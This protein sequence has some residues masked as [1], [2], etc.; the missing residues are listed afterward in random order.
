MKNQNTTIGFARIGSICHG[1]MRHRHLIPALAYELECLVRINRDALAA[2][3]SLEQFNA[4]ITEAKAELPNAENEQTYQMVDELFD[5]LNGFSPPFAYFGAHEGNGSD[6]GFWPC[7]D[8][9]REDCE[10][11]SSKRQEYPEA[12]FR[13]Y[14]L[15]VSDHGNATLY[16]RVSDEADTEIWSL[17]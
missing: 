3:G 1:T 15:H 13:G 14:W 10:F 6:F 16:E 9:A 2:N 5:A 11:V 4:I 7:L 12:D 8:S 17:V